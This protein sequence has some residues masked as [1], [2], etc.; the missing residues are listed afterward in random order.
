[1]TRWPDSPRCFRSPDHSIPIAPPKKLPKRRTAMA[2]LR[3]FLRSQLSERLLQLRK[4]EQGVISESIDSSRFPKQHA[5]GLS[6]KMRDLFAVPCQ[7]DHT[8]KSCRTLR[9]RNSD[10]I[11]QQLRIVSFIARIPVVVTGCR[12]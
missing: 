7:R 8:N 1:M 3:L 2:H 11:V 9:I 10:R 4:I 12:I 6:A 5:F